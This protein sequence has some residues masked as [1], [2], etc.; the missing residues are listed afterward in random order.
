MTNYQRVRMARTKRKGV[1]C[2]YYVT[3]NDA[4]AQYCGATMITIAQSLFMA[5]DAGMRISGIPFQAWISVPD[6]PC[7][8]NGTQPD[9]IV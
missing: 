6:G 1:S 3:G 8:V 9:G 7:P 5:A 4:A 2:P